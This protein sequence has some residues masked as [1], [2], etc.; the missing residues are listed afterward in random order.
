MIVSLLLST[1]LVSPLPSIPVELSARQQFMEL[2]RQPLTRDFNYAERGNFKSYGQYHVLEAL[3]STRRAC[4]F[5]VKAEPSAVRVAFWKKTLFVCMV[6][7]PFPDFG[8]SIGMGNLTFPETSDPT[9]LESY[10]SL[11]FLEYL[12]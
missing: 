8:G 2:K 6:R 7:Q 12:D 10:P 9:N 1:L 11:V 5:A 4:L 3:Q